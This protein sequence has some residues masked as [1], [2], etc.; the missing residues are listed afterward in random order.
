ML[1]LAPGGGVHGGEVVAEG[2]PERVAKVEGSYKRRCI[3]QIL[4]RQVEV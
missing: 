4:E 3:A 2:T 1:D